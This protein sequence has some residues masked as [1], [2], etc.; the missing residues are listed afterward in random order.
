[1]TAPDA[2]EATAARLDRVL[3]QM[4]SDPRA[5]AVADEL[6]GCLVQLY[7]AGLTRI[8]RIV[9]PERAAGL[10]ADPLVESLLLVHDLHP[11]DAGT[12]IRQGLERV[13]AR[14]GEVDYLGMDDA[15]IVC[16]RLPAGGGCRSS[17]QSV[18]LL[19]ETTVRQAAPEAAG[20]E[21]EIPVA[22]PPLLQV[23]RRPGV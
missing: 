4:R 5:A 12:R 23:S 16:V 15:G 18:R 8:V 22:P 10:C 19:I 14:T 9:G 21:V 13:R 1:M 17:V 20:V 3:E 11:V 7:G 6:V 2:A